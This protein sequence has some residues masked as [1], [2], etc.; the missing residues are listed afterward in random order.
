[1]FDVK[2]V[3]WNAFD[4]VTLNASVEN[5]IAVGDNFIFSHDLPLSSQRETFDVL[6]QLTYMLAVDVERPAVLDTT[7]FHN[8]CWF[9]V[10]HLKR[11]TFKFLKKL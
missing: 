2:I 3:G 6:N 11:I 1:M 9:L 10:S 5:N 7:P 8:T 4:K